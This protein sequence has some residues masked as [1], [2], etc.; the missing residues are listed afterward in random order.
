[1]STD[2]YWKKR[3]AELPHFDAAHTNQNVRVPE[4]PQAAPQVPQSGDIDLTAVLQQRLQQQQH[5]GPTPSAD[6]GHY[7]GPPVNVC[8]VR[9]NVEAYR[10]IQSQSFGTTTPLVIK[11]GPLNGVGGREFENKGLVKC[12]LVDNMQTIDLA[13]MSE[14]PERMI[15]LVQI[16]APFIGTLLVPE[17]AIVNANRPG[18]NGG[19]GL[20]QG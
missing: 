17:H 3:A 18:G 16:S 1:M 15:R 9:E 20:L 7:Q 4:I 2:A 6:M 13:E 5:M 11:V 8:M 14:H 10:Q 19:P 12:Y